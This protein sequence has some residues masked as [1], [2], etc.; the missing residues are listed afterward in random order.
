[1]GKLCWVSTTKHLQVCGSWTSFSKWCW[2]LQNLWTRTFA[3]DSTDGMQHRHKWKITRGLQVTQ[4]PTAEEQTGLALRWDQLRWKGQQ[5]GSTAKK[6]LTVV[7]HIHKVEKILM[8]WHKDGF[9]E[10]A[11]VKNKGNKSTVR[12]KIRWA[13]MFW[14][15]DINGNTQ[16]RKYFR[17]RIIELTLI[18][19]FENN[20]ILTLF[21]KLTTKILLGNVVPHEKLLDYLIKII[22]VSMHCYKTKVG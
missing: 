18:Q 4:R 16:W 9:Q 15:R 20:Q 14:Q 12:R 13:Q 1:M 7:R 11:L 21:W 5:Y 6:K 19:L 17:S 8:K 2:H 10:W 22:S 3:K